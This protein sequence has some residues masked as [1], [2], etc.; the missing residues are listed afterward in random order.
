M[1]N[2]C[3]KSYLQVSVCMMVQACPEHEVRNEGSWLNLQK[4]AKAR[5][6]AMYRSCFSHID[7]KADIRSSVST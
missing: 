4:L 2:R 3:W 6:M 1:I 5:I 7:F